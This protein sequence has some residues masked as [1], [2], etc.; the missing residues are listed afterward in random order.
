MLPCSDGGRSGQIV[1]G[2]R[3]VHSELISD[4][5]RVAN[6]KTRGLNALH[7][8][9]NESITTHKMWVTDMIINV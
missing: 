4:I 9:C 1:Y 2:G 8:E 7:Y 5:F 3:G 6:T